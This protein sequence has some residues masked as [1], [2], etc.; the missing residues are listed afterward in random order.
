MEAAE[1]RLAALKAREQAAKAE[2][3]RLRKSAGTNLH[4]RK[5]DLGLLRDAANR[6]TDNLFELRKHLV[7]K[8]LDPEAVDGMLKTRNLDYVA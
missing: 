3:D 8:G 2:A 7:E 6:W 1:A 4:A 5:K